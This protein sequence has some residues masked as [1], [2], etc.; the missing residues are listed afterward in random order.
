MC[1]TDDILAKVI[2]NEPHANHLIP[3]SGTGYFNPDFIMIWQLRWLRTNCPFIIHSFCVI[4]VSPWQRCQMWTMT[5]LHFYQNLFSVMFQ[6]WLHNILLLSFLLLLLLLAGLPPPPPCFEKYLMVVK[7]CFQEAQ[8][9][10][11]SDHSVYNINFNYNGV[12]Q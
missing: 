5:C 6:I 3:F 9:E 4:V 1:C 12:C 10:I 7:R 8:I 11:P 2:N